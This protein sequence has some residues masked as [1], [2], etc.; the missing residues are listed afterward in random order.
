[1]SEN[2]FE[3]LDNTAYRE[4]HRNMSNVIKIVGKARALLI[5]GKITKEEYNRIIDRF[6]YR[7]QSSQELNQY[8]ENVLYYRY[9]LIDIY[10]KAI[11]AY[12]K[13]Q[14]GYSKRDSFPELITEMEEFFK[15]IGCYNLYKRMK[16][17]CMIINDPNTSLNVC[18]NGGKTSYIVLKKPYINPHKSKSCT[19]VHEM[20]HAYYYSLI[21]DENASFFAR[22]LNSEIVSI[23]F[24]R[25]YLDFLRRYTNNE[26]LAKILIKNY[27]THLFTLTKEAKG[28]LEV[29]DKPKSDFKLTG[30]K[31]TFNVK[32]KEQKT[33]LYGQTYAIGNLGAT[34]LF[35]DYKHEPDLFLRYF[36]DFIKSI[37]I[38]DFQSV[39]LEHTDVT[40]LEECLSQNL[41]LKPKK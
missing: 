24:E 19:I 16:D 14:T 8:I 38:M 32:G 2:A 10:S 6:N 11:D 21:A 33:D 12:K 30:A 35:H 23:L 3:N 36:S 40:P 31:L 5:R 39:L 41:V 4:Y 28:V 13:Y 29:F 17:R 15:Y 20:G 27:E 34:R 26:E 37:K 18:I 7:E 25:L 9:G 1:M 22:D